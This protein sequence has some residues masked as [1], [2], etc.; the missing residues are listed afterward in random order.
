MRTES[1]SVIHFD[2]YNVMCT[3]RAYI[4]QHDLGLSVVVVY[5]MYMILVLAVVGKPA[6]IITGMQ[7]AVYHEKP[8]RISCVATSNIIIITARRVNAYLFG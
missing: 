8:M 7:R 5:Y 1:H 4:V 2:L 3:R 6:Y